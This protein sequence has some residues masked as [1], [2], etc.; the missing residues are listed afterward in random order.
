MVCLATCLTGWVNSFWLS[1]GSVTVS[2]IVVRIVDLPFGLE[3]LASLFLFK[4]YFDYFQLVL[5]AFSIISTDF[6]NVLVFYSS[7]TLVWFCQ[8]LFLQDCG[9][10][11]LLVAHQVLPN[12]SFLIPFLGTSQSAHMSHFPSGPD[13][14]I[15]FRCGGILAYMNC[16]M[17]AW[18]AI[19][20]ASLASFRSSSRKSTN[21]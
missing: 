15:F 11:Y 21:F 19:P 8:Y 14:L 9:S 1:F 12:H 4:D 17:M 10:Q 13:L 7:D 5:V 3:V 18:V 16:S 2:V 6:Y 20:N